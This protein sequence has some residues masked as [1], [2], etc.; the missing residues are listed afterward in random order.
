MKIVSRLYCIAVSM[1]ERCRAGRRCPYF[2]S[3]PGR[4]SVVLNIS[5]VEMYKK[6]LSAMELVLSGCLHYNEKTC[7]YSRALFWVWLNKQLV[8]GIAEVCC[9]NIRVDAKQYRNRY[10]AA[11]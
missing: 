7:K 5:Y 4:F 6:M 10:E 2:L 1:D 8:F 9:C 3:R 11:N